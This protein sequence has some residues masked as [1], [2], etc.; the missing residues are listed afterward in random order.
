VAEPAAPRPQPG[1]PQVAVVAASVVVVVLGAALVT[2][3]LPDEIQRLIFHGPVLIAVLVVGTGWVL[4]RIARGR[5][6][7]DDRPV[8]RQR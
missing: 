5:P 7:S 8:D 6:V 3:L 2:G 4:W 1:W